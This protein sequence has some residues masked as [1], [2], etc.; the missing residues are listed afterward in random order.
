[1]S[2]LER[3]EVPLAK[4]RCSIRPVRTPRV[5]ASSAAPAPT[6]PPPIT[7][8]SSSSPEAMVSMATCLASGESALLMR[9]LVPSVLVHPVQGALH[10]LLPSGVPLGALLVG[11]PRLPA[12]GLVPVGP[13]LVGVLPEPRGQTCSVGGAQGSGLGDLGLGDRNAEDVGLQLHA[14]A[15]RR[16]AAVDL[17]ALQ[18]HPG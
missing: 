18:A 12:L 9:M 14:E 6:T 8:T 5:A 10:G 13:Q 3:D 16:D 15:V 11:P 4:S 7:R 17:Q 1:M 2:L